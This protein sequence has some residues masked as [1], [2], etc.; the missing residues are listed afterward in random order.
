MGIFFTLFYIVVAYLAPVTIFGDLARYHIE[1]FLAAM[2]LIL[3]IFRLPGSRVASLP[4]TYAVIA[5]IVV[6]A[7]SMIFNGL[8]GPTVGALLEFI[9]AAIVFFFVFINFRTKFHLQ[10]LVVTLFGVA[11]FTIYKGALAQYSN[12]ELSPWVIR[13]TNADGQLFYRSRGMGFL[14][15]PNDFAQFVVGLIPCM[16]LLWRSGKFVA[17]GFLVI[18]PVSYLLYGMFMTHSR[19]GM[20]ALLAVAIVAGR[21]KLGVVPSLIAGAVLFI[22][23]SALGWSGGRDVSVESGNDRL[24]AWSTG[25]QLIRSHPVF[26]VGYQRF[27]EFFY[28]TAHNSVVVTAA[29]LGMVG[30]FFWFVMIV[31]TLRDASLTSV[32]PNKIKKKDD[33][34]HLPQALREHY[35][36]ASLEHQTPVGSMLLATS[37][38]GSVSS[39]TMEWP[40]LNQHA[41]EPEPLAFLQQEKSEPLTDAELRRMASLMVVSLAGFLTAGWFLSRA[42]TMVLFCFI[43]LSTSVYRLALDRGIAPNPWPLSTAARVAAVTS[44]AFIAIVY[45]ILRLQHFFHL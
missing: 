15:D 33:L 12:N 9:P 44:V 17:N 35:A 39:P 37:G 28:I 8:F 4:Q 3:T 20:V 40:G 24:E 30:L 23:L 32:D 38:A 36:T 29:E 16:F 18:L 11:A 2:A 34:R 43:G 5:L 21:R 22:G 14:N 31:P 25:I 26:G 41:A 7:L 19:G 45:V 27:N 10:L 6:V 13:M 42:Y 1:E